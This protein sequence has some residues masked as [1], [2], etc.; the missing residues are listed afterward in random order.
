MALSS[1]IAILTH[2]K[3]LEKINL[4]KFNEQSGQTILGIKPSK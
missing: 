3:Y 2:F 4:N 1:E